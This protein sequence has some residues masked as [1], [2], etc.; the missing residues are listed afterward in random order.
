M[1]AKDRP[2]AAAFRE[3]ETLVRHLGEEL[4]VWRKRAISAEE[5]LKEPATGRAKAAVA[6]ADGEAAVLKTRLTHAEG[7]IRQM[8]E[9]VRFLRQQLQSDN[10]VAGGRK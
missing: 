3:L 1:S 10:G 4:A 5:K 6:A 2:E 9:N 7:R 8:M